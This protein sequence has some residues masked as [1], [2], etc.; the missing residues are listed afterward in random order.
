MPSDLH[1]RS[2]HALQQGHLGSHQLGLT[3]SMTALLKS[4]SL[5]EHDLRRASV[6][7]AEVAAT[8]DREGRGLMS[9]S[10]T[11]HQRSLRVTADENEASDSTD[12]PSLTVHVT[13]SPGS[14]TTFVVARQR[15]PE[16]L[17]HQDSVVWFS[18][19]VAEQRQ[20]GTAWA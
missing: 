12:D 11:P 6:L 4:W 14:R 2:A 8:A 16:D 10:L 5:A 19:T 20:E 17:P 13:E 3:Y 7:T 1:S 15:G 9:M 18:L